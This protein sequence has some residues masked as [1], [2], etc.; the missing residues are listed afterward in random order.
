MAIT[1]KRALYALWITGIV[2]L[3]CLHFPHLLADFPNNSPWMDYSKYTD[4]GWYSNAAVRYHLT[5]HWYLRGDFNPAVALPIWPLL[6]AAVFHFTGVSLA[7]ARV[8][9]LIVLGLNLLLTYFVL[10]IRAPRWTALLAISILVTNPFL[11]AF[12]RLAILEPLVVCLL[13]VSWLLALRLSQSSPRARPWL[14]IAIG[15]VLCLQIFTKTTGIFLVPSTLFLVAWSCGFRLGASLR[16]LALTVAAAVVPWCAWYFLFVRPRYSVDYHYL[17]EVNRWPQPTGFAGHLAAYWFALHGTLWI[18]PTL[19]ILAIVLL[20]LATIPHRT[21]GDPGQPRSFWFNPIAIASLLAAA[22]YIGFA[23]A[24][25][26]PQ[27]RYY[28]TVVYPVAFLVA[29]AACELLPG[30]RALSLRAAG[31]AAVAAA[32][33]VIIT[34]AVRIGS[35]VRQPE[36]TWLT[37][38]HNIERYIDDHPAPNRVLL[39]ISADELALITHLPALCDDYGPWDLPYRIHTY[40]PS[41]YAT[42]N[43]L[44][45][46]TV[47]DLA[48]QYSL[49]QVAAFPAFDDPDRDVLILYRLHPLRPEKQNYVAAEEERDNAGK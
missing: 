47:E 1:S 42:W 38:A 22:G 18:S 21:S 23:G 41:W 16:A 4:E 8:V 19:C 46:G 7:A 15:I 5:G 39:S 45:A 32:T 24:Q 26:N 37:A 20:A 40:Q 48:T 31:A 2:A 12:S 36:Y 34:G 9:V 33:I 28:E 6:L 14:L 17:F 35:Y 30:G 44:D 25:N 49:E 29:L 3:F 11:Y 13:L 27:P 10:S 43:D